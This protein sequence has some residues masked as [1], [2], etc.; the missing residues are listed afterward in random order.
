MP[1][2]ISGVFPQRK[3]FFYLWTYQL[4]SF[5]KSQPPFRSLFYSDC[6]CQLGDRVSVLAARN[7]KASKSD[8]TP[9]NSWAPHAHERSK[10]SLV[11]RFNFETLFDI[12]S[13]VLHV[14]MM[15]EYLKFLQICGLKWFKILQ[16][17]FAIF[18]PQIMWI[19]ISAFSNFELCVHFRA[20]SDD[21]DFQL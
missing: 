20:A 13:L 8:L 16:L 9:N 19:K 10:Y 11:C 1:K 18:K 5:M 2:S 4:F 12:F 14:K 7:A 17:V 21:G 6:G 3:D 15:I